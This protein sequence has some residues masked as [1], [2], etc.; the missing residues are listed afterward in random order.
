M[1]RVVLQVVDVQC[2]VDWGNKR[3]VI[4]LFGLDVATHRSV[5][6]RVHGFLPYLFLQ[7][8]GALAC[9]LPPAA[10]DAVHRALVREVRILDHQRSIDRRCAKA[11]EAF[12]SPDAARDKAVRGIRW[13]EGGLK[14]EQ[15]EVSYD[16]TQR[17]RVVSVTPYAGPPVHSLFGYSPSHVSGLLKVEMTLPHYG[18]MVRDVVATGALASLAR[19]APK[20]VRRAHGVRRATLLEIGEEEDDEAQDAALPS[21]W[22]LTEQVFNESLKPEFRFMVD[23]DVQGTADLVVI[24]TGGGGGGAAVSPSMHE[25]S[26]TTGYDMHIDAFARRPTLTEKEKSE[27]RIFETLFAFDMEVAGARGIFPNPEE[28]RYPI[29]QISCCSGSVKD[30]YPTRNVVFCLKET[31]PIKSVPDPRVTNPEIVWVHTEQELLEAF[32]DHL[33]NDVDPDVIT[34]YNIE[35][36]DFKYIVTRIERMQFDPSLACWSRLSNY[37][38][39]NY[40]SSFESSAYGKRESNRVTIYGRIVVDALERYRR[41]FK[42]RS[43]KLDDIAFK[44]LGVK[45]EDVHHSQITPLWKSG[46]PAFR[47]RL[48]LYCLM[49]SVLVFRLMHKHQHW[50]LI[51]ALSSVSGVPAQATVSRGQ[52]IRVE[53]MLLRQARRDHFVAPYIPPEGDAAW[54]DPQTGEF[55]RPAPGRAAEIRTIALAEGTLTST[56]P[57]AREVGFQGATVVEPKKGLYRVP[58]VTLDFEGLY[59]SIMRRNNLDHSTLILFDKSGASPLDDLPADQITETPASTPERRIL[60]VKATTRK[61]LLPTILEGL[62][63]ARKAAK[64]EMFEKEKS[65]DADGRMVANNK[66]L[67]LKVTSNSIYGF[68]GAETARWPHKAI[69]ASVTAYGREGIDICTEATHRFDPGY[70]VIYGDTDSVMVD[71]AIKRDWGDDFEATHSREEI[72]WEAQRRGVALNDYINQFFEHPIN[73][74]FEKVFFYYLLIAKKRYAG[75]H[76]EATDSEGRLDI[77]RGFLDVKGMESTRRDN[78]LLAANTVKTCLEKILVNY[79]VSGAVAHAQ[80]VMNALIAGTVPFDDLIIS[81]TY[82]RDDYAGVQPHVQLKAKMAQRGEDMYQV[83]IGDRVAYVVTVPSSADGLQVASAESIPGN[84]GIA[85]YRTEDPEYAREHNLSID[86]LYYIQQQLLEPLTRVFRPVLGTEGDVVR[87]LLGPLKTVRRPA[88][89][90]VQKRFSVVVREALFGVGGALGM[91]KRVASK[92]LPVP[93]MRTLNSYFNRT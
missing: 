77:S 5:L 10:C 27:A 47:A 86:A 92:S 82:T 51:R 43:Y 4:A 14:A 62:Y 64:R 72:L 50:M 9:A 26:A 15:Q 31:A 18:N 63:L 29:I 48:A 56:A 34:G 35:N 87:T 37:Q 32:R 89:G 1:G 38:T 8:S 84:L 24:D 61:G 65:G 85:S 46:V 2:L 40:E 54:R 45:K 49:D 42:E 78:C 68:T 20:V 76:F 11:A 93:K 59:P 12:I 36:F 83:E 74:E 58:I 13:H 22:G 79:D 69:S 7:A 80:G 30:E 16:D 88:V 53:T 21:D 23:Y 19:P 70:D 55:A 66:Q 91:G 6:L 39:K 81:K 60:F 90:I 71:V 33:V 41:D 75:M 52:S 25:N 57:R 67:A 73:L 28:A 17:D 3:V 44:Y